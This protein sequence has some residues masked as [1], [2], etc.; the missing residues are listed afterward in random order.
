V[1]LPLLFL[2]SQGLGNV[3][4]VKAVAQFLPDE[5]GMAAMHVV[6]PAGDPRFGRPYGPWAG[7]GIMALWTAA[8]LLAGYFAMRRRDV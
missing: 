4:G 3:P 7:L 6:G 2:G 1:L 8:A 5:A